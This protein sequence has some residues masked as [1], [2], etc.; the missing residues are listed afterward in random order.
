M[1]DSIPTDVAAATAPSE[2]QAPAPPATLA[3]RLAFQ[4]KSSTSSKSNP[5]KWETR[6][7]KRLDSE[8]AI[9][10]VDSMDAFPRNLVVQRQGCHA[11]WKIALDD[12]VGRQAALV[13]GGPAAAVK[14]MR[15]F[16]AD[17]E[18]CR[19]ACAAL[20]NIALDHPSCLAVV[21]AG[22]A[23]AA[24]S[25][26]KSLK[27]DLEMQRLGVGALQNLAFGSKVCKQAVVDAHGAAAV[28]AVMVDCGRAEAPASDD[29]Y[30]LLDRDGDDSGDNE[31]ANQH[32]MWDWSIKEI[33]RNGCGAL[34]NL[35]MGEAS[36]KQH[37]CNV[38]GLE[39]IVS[40]IHAHH[41]SADVACNGCA[42][43]QHIATSDVQQREI[44]TDGK[45][46]AAARRLKV[47]EAGGVTAVTVAMQSHPNNMHMLQVGLAALR[48]IASGDA[49]CRRAVVRQVGLLKVVVVA[50]QTHAVDEEV[51]Q[52]G[53]DILNIVAHGNTGALKL[54]EIDAARTVA[55]SMT[56]F[57]ANITIQRSGCSALCCISGVQGTTTSEQDR[58]CQSVV[59]VGGSSAIV[60][61]LAE[62][63]ADA[64]VQRSGCAALQSLARVDVV[65]R[66]R[67][68]E[69]GACQW[70]ATAMKIHPDDVGVQREGCRA[71]QALSTSRSQDTSLSTQGMQAV[72]DA[73]GSTVILAALAA[74]PLD[75]DVQV[76]G[77]AALH[78]ITA[79]M[80]HYSFSPRR[81]GHQGGGDSRS[82]DISPRH[83]PSGHGS[84]RGS[85]M[86]Q[87]TSV[88]L[89]GAARAR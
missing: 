11:L 14:A 76:S 75:R 54:V 28:V 81:Q 20:W 72:V 37:V 25:A 32:P 9:K 15:S 46:L 10:L 69:A 39:A 7:N 12:I 13:C 49:A 66:D 47:V 68:I 85:N 80:R 8:A 33:Q 73:G 61:A 41:A 42:A 78:N 36:F 65:S 5:P 48:S 35:A 57:I 60:T 17:A 87:Q 89:Q 3:R 70:I 55:A 88:Q 23:M 86:R 52:I 4:R 31:D 40:A 45:S 53:C 18:L 56:K 30:P 67:L 26:L 84:A 1:S 19:H 24:V 44:S 77:N 82:F 63:P 34:R 58:I 21:D 51:Q 27:H 16:P 38:G 22:G 2:Q 79:A 71:L 62:H 50:M 6:V 43:L 64:I 74:H 59:E 29:L 83:A